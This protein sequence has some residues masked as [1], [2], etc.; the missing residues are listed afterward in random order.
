MSQVAAVLPEMDVMPVPPAVVVV[1]ID[2]TLRKHGE[3]VGD[4]VALMLRSMVE[5]GVVVV[6]CSGKNL[7]FIRKLFNFMEIPTPVIGS[8]NGGYISSLVQ[9]A[10]HH[11]STADRTKLRVLRDHIDNCPECSCWT[12]GEQKHSMITKRFGSFHRA[13]E[14]APIWKSHARQL[15]PDEPSEVFLYPPTDDAVDLVLNPKRVYKGRLIAMLRHYYPGAPIVVAEDG[16]NGMSM[17][18][19]AGVLPVCPSTADDQIKLAVEMQ[20]GMVAREPYSAG[21]LSALRWALRQFD[22]RV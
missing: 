2:G 15:F 9:G 11:D 14:I 12:E 5:Q 1:D 18:K 19:A 10:W 7:E 13:E 20:G 8:E 22:V 21:T 3:Y 16:L 4:G 6:P 17:V